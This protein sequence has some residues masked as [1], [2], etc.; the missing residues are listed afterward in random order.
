MS[1]G[2]KSGLFI[3]LT[4][5]CWALL[6]TSEVAFTRVHGSAFPL[7]SSLPSTGLPPPPSSCLS[8]SCLPLLASLSSGDVWRSPLWPGR[9]ESWGETRQGFPVARWW[10]GRFE[11]ARARADNLTMTVSRPVCPH[12][13]K[14]AP[15]SKNGSFGDYFWTGNGVCAPWWTRSSLQRRRVKRDISTKNTIIVVVFFFAPSLQCYVFI[16]S[17]IICTTDS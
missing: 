14:V 17:L 7:I 8:L 12:F 3:R 13:V 16:K 9:Q 15:Y 2:G 5:L 4:W 11:R 10:A 1:S 6:R